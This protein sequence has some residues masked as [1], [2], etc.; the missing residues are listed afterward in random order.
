M[1]FLITLEGITYRVFINETSND[2]REDDWNLKD[3]TIQAENET[4]RRK[5][6]NLDDKKLQQFTDKC[7]IHLM[8][9]ADSTI[10]S[11][12]RSIAKK[13]GESRCWIDITLREAWDILHDWRGGIYPCPEK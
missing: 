11:E 7:K 12:N 10:G 6:R 4:G 13:S 5:M 1:C 2:I 3:F 8:E 9:L